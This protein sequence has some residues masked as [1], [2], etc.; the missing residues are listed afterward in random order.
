MKIPLTLMSLDDASAFAIDLANTWDPMGKPV[1]VLAQADSAA[2]FFKAYV[3][4]EAE[5]VL[6]G[7]AMIPHR[8]LLRAAFLAVASD[9]PD[10]V[11]IWQSL[12][13]ALQASWTIGIDHRGNPAVEFASEVPLQQRLTAWSALGFFALLSGAPERT[14]VCQAAPCEEVFHDITKSGRQRFCSK[15]CGTRY[16]VARHRD[17]QKNSEID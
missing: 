3:K 8:D 17:R 10:K 7:E 5:F 4:N 2:H 13:H 6:L 11:E 16:N 15:R 9:A 12:E 14:R 1:D